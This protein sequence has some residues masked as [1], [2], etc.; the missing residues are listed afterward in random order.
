MK[1]GEIW[2]AELG[3]YRD[4]SGEFS[5][6]S[7]GVMPSVEQI[8]PLPILGLDCSETAGEFDDVED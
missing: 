4:R 1:R 7:G 8:D 6:P 2:W 5:S 3:P